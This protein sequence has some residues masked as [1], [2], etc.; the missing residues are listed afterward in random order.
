MRYQLHTQHVAGTLLGLMCTTLL[1]GCAGRAHGTVALLTDY[2]TQDHY[3][4]VL[5]A[6]VLRAN[7]EARLATITHEV[8]PYNIAQGAF[9]LAEAGS[10]FPAGTVILGVVDPGV[11]TPREPIV[12][13]TRAGHILV[14]PDNGLFDLL[15]QRDGG[16]P[17]V[18]RIANPTFVRAGAASSTFH[19]RDLFGPVAG[20]LSRGI[21]P[22]DVG[23]RLKN[24]VP[25]ALPRAA[26]TPDTLRGAIL[27]RDHYGNLLT[28]IPADWLESI[29]LGASVTLDTDKQTAGAV[30]V[31]TYADAPTGALVVLRN[32]SGGIEIARNQASAGEALDLHAGAAVTVRIHIEH[33]P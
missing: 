22:A 25:L 24:W 9:L 12:V 4:G 6:N 5:V 33:Q 7:P 21:N 13:V 31:R 32:A 18:Y 2:G 1:C 17:E 23:P 28:N 15:I 26:R 16:A 20:H 30:H 10:E 29:P 27:H 14:G 3:V 8:E 11:G 19:G